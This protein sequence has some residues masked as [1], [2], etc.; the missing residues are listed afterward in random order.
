MKNPKKFEGKTMETFLNKK[1]MKI[2]IFEKKNIK[3]WMLRCQI[4]KLRNKNIV[5]KAWKHLKENTNKK[6][7]NIN[8]NN[9]K[10]IKLKKHINNIELKTWITNWNVNMNNDKKKPSNF[11][12]HWKEKSMRWKSLMNRNDKEVGAWEQYSPTK[13]KKFIGTHHKLRLASYE[14]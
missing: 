2:R 13:S 3:C 4:W 11:W 9:H 14:S 10:T 5:F 1:L 6:Y 12:K 8:W 7:K